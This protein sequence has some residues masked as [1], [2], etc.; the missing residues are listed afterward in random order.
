MICDFGD[1][2]V[3]PFPF[4]DMDVAKSRPALVLS[5]AGFNDANGQTIVAMVT[6]AERSEWP[7]D[8]VLTD[9]QAAG[10]HHPSRVRMK[11]FTLP[12]ELIVRRIGSL[13]AADLKSVKTAVR[14]HLG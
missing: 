13:A 14:R 3:V 1:V 5:K 6:T 12:N 9:N 11:L 4:V 8:I 2:T 7:S 10:L